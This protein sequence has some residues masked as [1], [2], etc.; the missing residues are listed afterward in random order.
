MTSE[1]P[2]MRPAVVV[3]KNQGENRLTALAWDADGEMWVSNDGEEFTGSPPESA[4]SPLVVMIES[5]PVVS[6]SFG[7]SNRII[8]DK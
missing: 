7:S 8:G 3:D 4:E 5:D 6:P 1:I 2:E